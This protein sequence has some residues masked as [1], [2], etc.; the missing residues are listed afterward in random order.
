MI[1]KINDLLAVLWLSMQEYLD[2]VWQQVWAKY[3]FIELNE[4]TCIYTKDWVSNER[5]NKSIVENI[6]LA[7]QL[8]KTVIWEGEDWVVKDIA[9]TLLFEDGKLT[10][11]SFAT[12]KKI[13]IK[14]PLAVTASD[15][16]T[17]KKEDP[18]D[19]IKDIHESLKFDDDDILKTI[20]TELSLVEKKV[21]S[22]NFDWDYILIKTPPI[23]IKCIWSRARTNERIEAWN[24]IL[25]INLFAQE[26]NATPVNCIL[27]DSW[28]Y[29]SNHHPHHQWWDRL[30][31]KEFW[32]I[33]WKVWKQ[34]N[35]SVI[36]DVMYE[37]LC[38]CNTDSEAHS[39]VEFY[40]D[41]Q[42]C[43]K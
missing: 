7:I 12:G 23:T 8:K 32:T 2:F 36:Y 30:C 19:M 5:D 4:K 35:L 11:I 13:E 34:K 17:L 33:T 43:Q 38:T 24:Y 18:T 1:K 25:K 40:N 39:R 15:L 21:E 26:F 16:K 9:H 28:R 14:N 42:K 29:Y 31:L 6:L 27:A 41:L 22:I 10:W 20:S 3:V 37:W